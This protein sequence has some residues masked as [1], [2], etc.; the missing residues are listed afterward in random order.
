MVFEL[1]DNTARILAGC[2]SLF[3]FFI[4]LT[5]T[6]LAAIVPYFMH[7]VT[8]PDRFNDKTRKTAVVMLWLGGFGICTAF[9]AIFMGYR[10]LASVINLVPGGATTYNMAL[11]GF[12]LYMWWADSAPQVMMHVRTSI[13]YKIRG[14]YVFCMGFMMFLVLGAT[15]AQSYFPAV[16]L[17]TTMVFLLPLISFMQANVKVLPTSYPFFM[18]PPLMLEVVNTS[19]YLIVWIIAILTPSYSTLPKIG[20]TVLMFVVATVAA[21]HLLLVSS[22]AFF[23]A[24]RLHYR[25]RDDNKFSKEF[26][27]PEAE[28][29]SSTAHVITGGPNIFDPMSFIGHAMEQ[30]LPPI[31]PPMFV[32]GKMPVHHHHHAKH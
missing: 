20:Y 17:P 12:F 28:L 32:Q 1:D 26:M 19:A 11:V 15:D 25:W 27:G 8:G 16:F 18:S 5:V 23:F 7:R 6:T 14:W 31:L 4:A 10:S 13:P 2:F 21:L 30:M 24:G 3:F 29:Y 22:I 9:A